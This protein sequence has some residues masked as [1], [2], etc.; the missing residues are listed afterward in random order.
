[1]ILRMNNSRKFF[2]F[3]NK[4]AIQVRKGQNLVKKGIVKLDFTNPVIINIPIGIIINGIYLM[5]KINSKV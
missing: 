3:D 4:S 1:M 5:L 2:L